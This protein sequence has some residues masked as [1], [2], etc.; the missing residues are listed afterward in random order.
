MNM[1]RRSFLS[2]CGCA[3]MA[4]Q[5]A[6]DP[7]LFNSVG[8]KVRVTRMKVFGVSLT[9]DSDR[10][11]VFVKIETN[12][13]VVGWGEAT[14]EGKAAAVMACVEDFKEHIIGADPMM[15]E[16]L[17]QSMYVH[18]F[19]RAGP[20]IGSAISGI[21]QALWDIRG[22]LMGMPVYK[23]LGGAYD[24]RGVRGYYH[25]RGTT[26][27]QLR[28]QREIARQEGITCFKGGIPGYYEWIDTSAKIRGAVKAMELLREG[29]GPDIDIGVDFHAK[30]SPSVAAVLVKEVEPLNLLFVEEPCPPENVKAM[31]RISAR[32]TTPIATGERLIASYGCRELIESGVVDILQPDINHAGGITA[33][34]KIGAMADF[35]GISMAPHACEGPIGGLATIHVDAATPNFLVQEICS[36][37]KPEMK[38]KVWEEWLGFPAM[39]MVQGR[40][41]LPEKPGLGFEL[42]EESLKKYPFAGTKA[43]ARVFHEDGSVAEW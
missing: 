29:L 34:W 27:S 41:P 30:T 7:G 28:E 24:T 31:A 18:S 15:V 4:M 43:M 3:P 8:T 25:M 37:V 9:P 35:A 22:K 6:M 14:L 40:F 26:L 11:Y 32:S 42:K 20:V 13:G 21:D 17:W 10:P 38:E 1:D 19:Y 12:Q 16:H 5:T 39:R 2:A 33:L 36:G 23:L